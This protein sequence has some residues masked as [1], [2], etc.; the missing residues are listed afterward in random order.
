[1]E[2]DKKVVPIC[3]KCK[4]KDKTFVNLYVCL[5]RDAKITCFLTGRTFC[6]D[7]NRNGECRL[8]EDSQPVL[9]EKTS[10]NAGSI[11]VDLTLNTEPFKKKLA[12]LLVGL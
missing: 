9:K 1:M 2:N 10:T 4:Y 3:D 8:Y 7:I 6:G 5:H 12:E 11:T